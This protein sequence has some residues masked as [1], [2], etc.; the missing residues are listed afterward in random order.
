MDDNGDQ[1]PNT[2]QDGFLAKR[3]NHGSGILLAG[4]EPLIGTVSAN[5][6]VTTGESNTISVSNV[7]TTGT[8]DKVIAVVTTP[9]G[10]VAHVRS[11]SAPQKRGSGLELDTLGDGT[12][13]QGTGSRSMASRYS[14]TPSKSLPE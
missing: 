5:D 9:G 10:E 13:S 3:Q 7:T 14:F 8:I 4:D 11:S 1:I 12:G 6:E 2:K